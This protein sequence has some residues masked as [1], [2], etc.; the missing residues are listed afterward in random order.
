[1]ADHDCWLRPENMKTPRTLYKIDK[2]TP[3]TE[4]AAET[5]AAMAAASVVF[6]KH[7]HT[8]SR[9]LLNKAKL[10]RRIFKYHYQ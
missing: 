6:R 7:N 4:I 2:K 5:A 3:G 8:Y 1:M 9:R 10:V